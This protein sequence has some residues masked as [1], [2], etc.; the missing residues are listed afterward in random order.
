MMTILQITPAYKPAYIY[1]GPTLSVS[2]LCEQ[3]HKNKIKISVLTST[4]N[5]ERE[6]SVKTN[7]LNKVSQVNVYYYSR[8]TKDH[9]HFAP[10]LFYDLVKMIKENKREN[11]GELIVHI[12]SWWNTIAI[13]TSLISLWYKVPVVISPRGMLTSYTL[14]NRNVVYKF[15][16]HQLLGQHLLNRCYFHATT[17]KE[18]Q[19]IRK[20][21]EIIK[22]IDVIPNFVN[23]PAVFHA[24]KAPERLPQLP[25]KLLYLSRIEEKKGL[26]ILI[27]ALP[28]LKI[29][30]Q[31]TIAG[32]G[33]TEYVQ[34]LKHL[35]IELKVDQQIKWIGS[36]NNNKK[37]DILKNND[38]FIL[39][40]HNENFANVVIES[41]VVGTPV[42][43]TREVGLAKYVLKNNLGW[44]AEHRPDDLAFT[45]T[46]AAED[47]RKRAWIR[48]EAPK[49]IRK[50]YAEKALL[51][52]YA[53]MYHKI[54]KHVN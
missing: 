24:V 1:G 48:K 39:P 53:Y 43:I 18:E 40:S 47:Y 31:L 50:D 52:K 20:V 29:H 22:G 15:F 45:I 28:A 10:A 27:T 25:L 2:R 19:D 30:W 38:L 14:R 9:T 33:E 34:K 46:K 44:I 7:A 17:D 3:L 8:L 16:I 11:P 12:H 35:S 54:L 37:F 51:L 26:D 21:T 5:G 13:F 6:L 41:L 23:Y 49:I 42:I 36:V 32:H 4:A